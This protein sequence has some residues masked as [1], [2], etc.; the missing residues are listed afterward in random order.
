MSTTSPHGTFRTSYRETQAGPND[1]IGEE[2]IRT[3][4]QRHPGEGIPLQRADAVNA[5]RGLAT[6]HVGTA[7]GVP[8]TE[9][10]GTICL[11]RRGAEARRLRK[12]REAEYCARRSIGRCAPPT[13]AIS[14][15]IGR[16]LEPGCPYAVDEHALA[17]IGAQLSPAVMSGFF[18]AQAT[19]F[20]WALGG[21]DE[22]SRAQTVPL[23]ERE[24]TGADDG[25][26]T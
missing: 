15:H 20:V 26:G 2:P 10:A 4:N 5:P 17:R 14:S 7:A 3:C 25:V 23:R 9:T 22:R 21:H 8:S 6:S 16:R 18:P 11:R 13:E 1:G 12:D 24:P 19:L